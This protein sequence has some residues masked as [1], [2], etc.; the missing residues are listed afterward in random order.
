MYKLFHN[1]SLKPSTHQLFFFSAPLPPSPSIRPQCLLLPSLCPCVCITQLPFVG[2]NMQYLFFC[3][4]NSLLRII[5]SILI[6]VP[7]KDMI[8]F[9]FMAAKYFVR[10]MY[11][12]FSLSRLSLIGIQADSMS[13]PFVNGAKVNIHM[14]LSLWQNDLYLFGVYS[15]IQWQF[16][17]QLFEKLLH[18]F[19]QWLK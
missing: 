8:P 18:C 16:C 19:P 2:E 4:S 10:Y 12:T 11:H 6:H 9:F 7:A 17:F 15:V 1:P 14:H 5:A 13:L 3:S